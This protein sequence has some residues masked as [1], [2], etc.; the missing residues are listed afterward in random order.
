[1]F[2]LEPLPYAYNALEPFIDEAT[3]KVHHDKHHQ[4][5]CDKFNAAIKGTNLEKFSS[6]EIL[7]SL[8]QVPPDIKTAV[9]NHGGGFVN[10]NFFWQSL[11]KGT[12]FKGEVALE[13]EKK[14]G[15][16]DKFKEAWTQSATS[17][18]G[19]GWTWLVY[20]PLKKEL[21]IL[22]TSNQDS[23]LSRSLIPLLC[24]DVWEHAYYL[25]YQNRRAEY[26]ENFFN[27]INW[28]KVNQLFLTAKKR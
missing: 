4:T 7:K 3:M 25:K 22:N 13:I 1:M 12:S 18:F 2:K 24:I 6:E 28:E 8:S 26:V 5:Y 10:H 23:P 11:K 16:Y 20:E 21:S 27:I 9:I 14:F 19:S 17:L 15:G